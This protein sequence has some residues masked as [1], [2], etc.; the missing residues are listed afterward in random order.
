MA[1]PINGPAF[2][3]GATMEDVL[4]GG[5]GMGLQGTAVAEAEAVLR[6]AL[7]RRRTQGKDK[8]GIVLAYTSNMVSSGL[9]E[10]F[11]YMITEGHVDAIMST[12]G[13]LEEDIIKC[14][15][16]T[17]VGDF[18]L[19]GKALRKDSL[20]RVGNLLI[21][22]DNYVHFED[23][24]VPVLRALHIEQCEASCAAGTTE[25]STILQRTGKKLV[26]APG[27][28]VLNLEDSVIA[29]CYR[30]GVPAFCPAFT[31]GS[32]GDMLFFYNINH[33]GMIVDPLSDERK[34]RKLLSTFD[35]VNVISVGAGLPKHNVLR[36]AVKSSAKL[37]S[38]VLMT[39]SHETDGCTSSGNRA[40]DES[41]DQLTPETDYARINTDAT[42]VFPQLVARVFKDQPQQ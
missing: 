11:S 3:R 24:F 9:R 32:M 18:A 17:L 13:G 31:D 15:G 22:N 23:F 7:E 25:P 33:K 5:A 1:V 8:V 41:L 12:A 19:P 38:V 27:V 20:N 40:D 26:E 39:T 4:R 16:H 14:L 34:L 2:E 42:L 6:R 36:A 28:P 29:S 30:A 35:E 10:V 37:A 21:P